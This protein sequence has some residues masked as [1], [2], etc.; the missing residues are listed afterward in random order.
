MKGYFFAVAAATML[1]L[2]GCEAIG[3][4]QGIEGCTVLKVGLDDV[5]TRT[6]LGSSDAGV[7]KVF[8]SDGD[9]L[10]VNGTASNPLEGLAPGT[11]SV[12]FTFPGVLSTPYNLL[13]PASFYK[14]ATTITL[15]SSQ[16]FAAGTIAPDTA[17]LA[18]YSASGE[19]TIAIGHLCTIIRISVL[20]DPGVS[21]SPLASVHFRGNAGEQVCGDFTI[22]YSSATLTAAGSGTEVSL[23]VNQPLSESEALDLYLTVPS[24]TYSSGFTVVFEDAAHRSMTRVKS[25][26]AVL[27]KGKLVNLTP[28]VNFV[29]SAA[30]L[31]IELEEV[32]EVVLPPDG[33]NIKGRVVDNGSNPVAGVVVSDGTQCVRTMFDGTFYMTSNTANVKFV[34]ISTPSGYLPEVSGGIPQFYKAKAGITPSAGVYDFGDFVITPVAN[35]NRFTLLITAD[36]QPRKFNWTLDKVAYKSLDVCQDL[37]QELYDVSQGIA[38]RQV[39]G[40]CLGDVVHEDMS[41]YEQYVSALG[42]LG[43][44]TYNIIGNHDNDYNVSSDDEAAAPYESYFGPRNY[45]FNI[46]GIH[47]VMLDNLIQGGYNND[48]S[49]DSYDQGLTDQIWTWLQA[50]MAFVPTTT[51][52]M[53]CAHSPMFKYQSGSERTNTAYH[54]GTTS[55]K[56]GG[57]YGYGDLFDKYDEVHAWAGHTH[58]GFNFVYNP[59]HRHKNIQVHTLARS[60]GELWT[61]EYLAN[62]TPRGFTV[63]EVNNGDISWKFHPL[64]R[65][66]GAFQGVN[67]GYCSAGAPAYTWRDWSYNASGVA[68]MNGGGSLTEDYQL[69]AYPRGAYGD[70]YVYANVF[71]WDE[72]WDNPV[73]TP[74]GGAPVEMTR[75][76]TPGT[77]KIADTEKIYDKA[78]TEFRTWYKTYA[79]KS[80]GS[81]AALEGYYTV[82][83]EVDGLI[84]TLFRA[85]AAASPNSGTVSVTDRFGNVYSS[86]VSW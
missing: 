34:H 37:Y 32:T 46:G 18:G 30:A 21:A 61:N 71:L 44:P 51:K 58:S 47:F 56:N 31:P 40:I 77:P 41:L 59:G 22:D 53:V 10:C 43:Y 79:N 86:H 26:E 55:N 3:P 78:D 19:G 45:S 9:R 5:S 33:Y 24:G 60:T 16:S 8:W 83:P 39:Y 29:P 65:Q 74:D 82:A 28:A 36:P 35:P 67:T 85:P 25:G 69:H 2:A 68:V 63:V 81:L 20:K 70:N 62:G 72:M 11:S 64:T 76:Y 66:R 15:P 7:R 49:Y 52:I 23:T 27:G 17:P 80:G 1:A 14:N 4:E 6:S 48:R 54:G 13:Y 50:D 42:T 57:A 12:S 84:T 75:I 38:G 73:W